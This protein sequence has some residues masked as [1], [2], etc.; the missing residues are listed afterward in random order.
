MLVFETGKTF[1]VNLLLLSARAD[2]STLHAY[3]L[4]CRVEGGT[5]LKTVLHVWE[6]QGEGTEGAHGLVTSIYTNPSLLI[7]RNGHID[8]SLLMSVKKNWKTYKQM[9][10][11]NF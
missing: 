3:M 8:Q 10:S 9:Y 2:P 6:G 4:A 5:S 7:S 11:T 1:N